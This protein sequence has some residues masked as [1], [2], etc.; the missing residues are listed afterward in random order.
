MSKG[1]TPMTG[2]TDQR[3][4]YEGKGGS[5]QEN[6]DFGIWEGDTKV[7]AGVTG[8]T[9][10]LIECKC[11]GN[12]EPF[13]FRSCRKCPLWGEPTEGRLHPCRHQEQVR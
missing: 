12:Q 5:G 10:G 11:Q 6:E 7:G 4:G 9:V 3:R 1:V 2:G 13:E 8:W